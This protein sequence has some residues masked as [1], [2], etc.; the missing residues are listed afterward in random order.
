MELFDAQLFNIAS[1]DSG[2]K[3]FAQDLMVYLLEKYNWKLNEHRLHMLVTALWAN[4]KPL[5]RFKYYR[6]FVYLKKH[7]NYE[8]YTS[9]KY[10][11]EEQGSDFIAKILTANR[12]YD[13]LTFGILE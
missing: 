5:F 2:I 8:S 6:Y 7:D 1:E 10:N 3:L 12:A 9:M 4:I 13:L 11:I